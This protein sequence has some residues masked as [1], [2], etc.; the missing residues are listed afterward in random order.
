MKEAMQVFERLIRRSL[1]PSVTFVLAFLVVDLVSGQYAGEPPPLRLS[2]WLGLFRS[3]VQGIE[4]VVGV[5]AVIAVLGLGFALGTVQQV[6]FDNTL[7]RDFDASRLLGWLG[8]ETEHLTRLRE[9]V[10]EKLRARKLLE[11]EAAAASDVG[12]LETLSDRVLYEVLGAIDPTDTRPYVDS[13]KGLGVVFGSL[14][15]ALLGSAIYRQSWSW[16]SWAVGLAIVVWWLGRETVKTQYR[17][18]ALRLYVN[19]LLLPAERIDRLV[20]GGERSGAWPGAGESRT[21]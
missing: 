3:F 15:M 13:A 10:R 20:Y 7:R 6:L 1:A 19:F 21:G 5:L 14:I 2:Y 17:G 11:S 18:R 4:G 9:R 8:S 16:G 12:S